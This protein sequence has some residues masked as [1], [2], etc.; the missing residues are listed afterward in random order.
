MM[1]TLTFDL[2]NGLSSHTS[3]W[4]VL[5]YQLHITEIAKVRPA[6][7]HVHPVILLCS[8]R[9]GAYHVT[10]PCSH[11]FRDEVQVVVATKQQVNTMLRR[12]R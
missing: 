1:K 5:Q 6:L 2:F 11:A 4:R 7:D 3:L 10:V 8:E 9:L 12:I